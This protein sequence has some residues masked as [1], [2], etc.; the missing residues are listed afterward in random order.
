VI[1]LGSFETTKAPSAIA[2]ADIASDRIPRGS[3]ND[4]GDGRWLSRALHNSGSGLR[5]NPLES[6]L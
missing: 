1:D 3:T 2:A 5:L 6:K 4:L